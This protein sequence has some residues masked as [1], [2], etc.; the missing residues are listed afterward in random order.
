MSSD[1]D[2]LEIKNRYNSIKYHPNTLDR[3]NYKKRK[4]Q[5]DITGC[6]Y[7]KYFKPWR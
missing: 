5:K 6:M 3:L 7:L 1:S 4:K 2:F